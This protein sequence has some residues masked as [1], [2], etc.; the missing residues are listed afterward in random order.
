MR[1]I[2]MDH[3][4][5]TPVHPE[6]LDAMLPYYKE[7]YGNASSVHSFGRGARAAMEE[8][9]EGI[10]NF[11][12]A[13]AREIIFTSG[14]TEADNNAIIGSAMANSKKGNHIITSS[15]EHHAILNTCKYMEDNGYEVSYLGVDRYGVVNPDDVREAI[16]DKTV[17]ISIM[18][19]NNEIGTIEPLQEIGQIAKEKGIILHSDAVQGLGKIPLNVDELGLDLMSISAHKIYGPKGIGALYARRGV[20]M[21]PLI[22]GGHHERN[23]RAGTEN[24]PGVVGFGKAIEIA[25]SDMEEEGKRQWSLTEKLKDGI[26]DRLEYVYANS[27]PTKRL[28]GTMNL[29]FDFLE[30]ESIILNLDMKGVGVSTGSAC[31]SGSLEASHVLTALGLP[32]ATAQGAIRFSLGRSNTEEDVDYIIGEL[33]PI[34]ERLRSMSPLY[35]DKMKGKG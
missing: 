2:Y 34:V 4:S 15:I 16:T 7:D 26:Q 18:Y 29:S 1:R 21:H 12:G 13:R 22:R 11:I 8:A 27:H 31:T 25:A 28:P 23:R 10:A 9:R 33:P 20:R 3:N 19:A 14:G 17:L 6:V 5:T 24:V 32:P 30:G 35:A